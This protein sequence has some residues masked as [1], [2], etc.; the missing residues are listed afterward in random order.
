MSASQPVV[1]LG[2]GGYGRE[3]RQY[4]QDASIEVLGFLDDDAQALEAFG[5]SEP[6]LGP[7]AA[8]PQFSDARFLIALGDPLLR[9]RFALELRGMG[10][11]FATLI[12]P[13]AYVAESAQVEEGAIVCPFA[14]V[15]AN[16]VLGVNVS[17]NVYASVGH[18]AVVESH[19]VLS[20]YCALTGNTRV[21]EASLLGTHVSVT[22]GVAIGSFSQVAAGST[23]TVDCAPGSLLAGNPAK[24]RVMFKVPSAD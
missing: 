4:C 20:P 12:H 8:A 24:G 22:P 11:R 5:H 1:I 16:S 7:L 18:D 13:T 19:A 15:G 9:R 10:A 3:L 14:L 17:L 6:L 23:V 21:G 2:A